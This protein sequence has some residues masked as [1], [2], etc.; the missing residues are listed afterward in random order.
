LAQDS[1]SRT[2][3]EETD[4]RRLGQDP[5][6][7]KKLA[8]AVRAE[9]L[10]NN[11]EAVAAELLEK[12]K[13]EGKARRT[14]EKMAWLIGIAMPLIG[15]RPVSEISAAEVLA[16]LRTVE[17]RG[18]HEAARKL[19]AVIGQVFRYAIATQRADSDPTRD[20]NGA[21]TTPTVTPHAAITEPKAFGALLR[22]IDGYEGAPET[23]IALQ[24]L[25][26]LFVRPGELR[27]AEWTEVDLDDALW[28]IP[29]AKMKMRR[30]HRIPLAPQADDLLRKL[31][32][33][34]GQGKYLFPA[35]HYRDRC[36]SEN[37]LNGALRRLGFAQA[38]MTSHGFR[39]SASSMLNESGLWHPDAIERQLAHV[40]RNAVRR[41]YARADHWDER[42]RMMRWWANHCDELRNE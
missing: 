15:A 1:Q 25:A 33:M 35:A 21:L 20:L 9:A 5:S 27:A 30:E 13:R 4:L 31:E 24:L 38:E 32:A 19:R 36:M 29:A 41:A 18:K 10:A 40:D 22:A 14:L 7:A 37:T 11:F 6:A 34:T 23:M 17:A 3:Y 16:V 26:L 8:K 12:K 2:A 28:V 39:A 42:V